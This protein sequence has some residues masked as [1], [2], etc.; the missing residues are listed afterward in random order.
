MLPNFFKLLL[1]PCLTFHGVDLERQLKK[2]YWITK[3]Q[4]EFHA[5]IARLESCFRYWLF[6][7]IGQKEERGK[8]VSGV[9]QLIYLTCSF[10]TSW[11]VCRDRN[12]IADS[13]V[14]KGLL[15]NESWVKNWDLALILMR[16][17]SFEI[18]SALRL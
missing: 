14:V 2:S 6:G 5:F 13:W 18:H 16:C 8:F 9:V 11:P 1:A 4:C 15:R 10:T 3:S 17:I 12:Q 7:Y